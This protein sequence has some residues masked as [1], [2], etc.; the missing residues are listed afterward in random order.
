MGKAIF[1]GIG[2][3]LAILGSTSLAIHSY[4]LRGKDE[5]GGKGLWAVAA[6]IGKHIE[7]PH[8]RPWA[9]LGAGAVISIWSFTLMAAAEGKK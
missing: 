4:E 6:P 5:A 8:W 9:L 2:I 1:L 3:T 7:P